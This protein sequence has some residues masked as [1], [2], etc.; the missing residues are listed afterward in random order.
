MK[1]YIYY[2]AAAVT[3]SLVTACS[4]DFINKTPDLKVTEASIFGSATRLE[5]AIEGTYTAL[6][7]SNSVSDGYFM[8]VLLH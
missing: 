2:I 7:G 3:M 1:K 8:E 4:E 6:K 5:A